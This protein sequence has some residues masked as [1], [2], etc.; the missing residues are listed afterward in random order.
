M[1]PAVSSPKSESQ[2][3]H[4]KIRYREEMEMFDFSNSAPRT[5]TEEMESAGRL[6]FKRNKKN[7]NT[8]SV[9]RTIPEKKEV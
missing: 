8:N 4:R 5:L 6:R 1:E 2:N 3:G 9:D 7:W